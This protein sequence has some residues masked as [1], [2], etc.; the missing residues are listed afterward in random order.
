[1]L[2]AIKLLILSAALVAMPAAVTAKHDTFDFELPHDV[3]TDLNEFNL[4]LVGAPSGYAAPGCDGV[5]TFPLRGHTGDGVENVAGYA[6]HAIDRDGVNRLVSV[7]LFNLDTKEKVFGWTNLEDYNALK[8][9]HT[10]KERLG[11]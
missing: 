7:E 2:K 9:C 11:V 4:H 8:T 10:T 5:V 1:V 6:I 3:A